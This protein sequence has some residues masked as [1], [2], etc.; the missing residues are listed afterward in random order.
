MR[1]GYSLALIRLCFF[2]KEAMMVICMYQLSSAM[3][4]NCL[5]KHQFICYCE[6]IFL[7]VPNTYIS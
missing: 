3:V 2:C 5:V 6:G 7:D 4:P 1:S